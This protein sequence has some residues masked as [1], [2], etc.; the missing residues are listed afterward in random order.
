MLASIGILP[1][2]ALLY[3]PGM[4]S[5]WL[6]LLYLTMI[7][8]VFLDR[9]IL[10]LH[11]VSHRPLFKT[12]YRWLNGYVPWVLGPFFGETPESYFSH[13]VGMHHVEENLLPDLS[14]TMPYQRDRALD[15]L[16][17]FFRFISRGIA[18][19]VAYFTRKKR[20][21]LR[22]RLLRGET[23]F[24]IAVVGL[25]FVNWQA[26][27]VVFVFPTIAVQVPDD[28]RQLGV[29]RLHRRRHSPRCLFTN[30][31]T[32]LAPRYNRRCFNDGYHIGH[33]V[34]ATRHWSE[35]PADFEANR[36]QYARERA[37]VFKDLDYFGVWWLLMW[38]SYPRLARHYVA[39]AEPRPSEAEIID[40][41]RERT[42]A[43]PAV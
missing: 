42:R 25:M 18:E 14:S 27:V 6:G 9:L 23:L 1:F 10:M 16:R 21:K 29:R 40:L 19:L 36:D 11:N 43:F 5:W 7:S 26:T 22:A 41:L 15:F 35:M 38:R 17:Y 32:C 13:H 24:W 39:L 28:G 31:I 4:F 37:V 33:H 20:F 8:A 12:R 2:A 3:V 34:S 30:S